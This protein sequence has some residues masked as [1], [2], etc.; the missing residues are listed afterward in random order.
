MSEAKNNRVMIIVFPNERNN[1]IT[2]FQHSGMKYFFDFNDINDEEEMEQALILLNVPL[3][4][5]NW[6]KDYWDFCSSELKKATDN[7]SNENLEKLIIQF[8]NQWT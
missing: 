6:V 8:P 3:P 4:D 2:T 1:R 5:K 7:I